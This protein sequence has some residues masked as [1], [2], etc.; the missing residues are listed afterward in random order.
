MKEKGNDW[1]QLYLYIFYSTFCFILILSLKFL[2]ALYKSFYAFYR[3]CIVATCTESAH[4]AV[5]FNT[6]HAL[7]CCKIEERFLQILILVVHH[8]ANVHER[9]VIG[10]YRTAEQFITVNLVIKDVG[11]FVCSPVHL[12]YTALCLAPAHGFE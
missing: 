9:T 4:R 2:H 7:P 3:L 11:T 8:K 6:Y 1:S 12:L 5:T 10:C